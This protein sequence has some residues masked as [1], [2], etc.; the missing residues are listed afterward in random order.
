MTPAE[1]ADA[2]LHGLLSQDEA[3]DF[4]RQ[5]DDD[6]GLREALDQARRRLAVLRESLPPAETPFHLVRATLDRIDEHRTGYQRWRRRGLIAIVAPLATAAVV[7]LAF[8]S[9]YRNLAASPVN[10]ELLGQDQ[11]LAGADAGLRIRLSDRRTQA[12]LAGVPVEITLGQPGTDRFVSLAQFTTD[13][14]GTGR[15]MFRIPDWDDGSYPLRVVAATDR[16]PEEIRQT[17]RLRRSSKLMLTTDKPVYQPGQTIRIRGLILRKPDLKPLAD[18]EAVF[19]VRDPK[20]NTIFRRAGKTSR[21]GITAADCELAD[22]IPDGA[23][24]VRCQVGDTATSATVRVQKYVLA[25]FRVTLNFDRPW[26]TPGEKLSGT[27]RGAYYHGQPVRD[28]EWTL[29]FRNSFDGVMQRLTGKTGP[30]GSASFQFQLPPGL[31][32]IDPD[33]SATVRVAVA[34]RDTAGQEQTVAVTR[35]IVE[36]S[37]LVELIPESG[38]LVQGVANTVYVYAR[39]PD[40]KPS[41]V[42]GTATIDGIGRE[43][44]TDALG[45]GA[46]DVTPSGE[47][48]DVA[49]DAM[50]AGGNRGT[51]RQALTTGR[52]STDFLVRTDKAVYRGGD[53]MTIRVIG[54][55]VEP[56]F[57]DLIKDGQTLRTETVPV[58][59]GA[60]ELI[61]DLPAELAGTIRLCAYRFNSD[62]LPIRKLRL[63]FVRPARQLQLKVATDKPEY[64]PGDP[65]KL[66]FTVT[67]RDG[68]PAPGALSLAAVDEVVFDVLKSRPGMEEAFYLLEQELLKPIYTIYPWTPEEFREGTAERLRFEQAIFSRTAGTI[69]PPSIPGAATKT[70]QGRFVVGAAPHTMSDS[71]FARKSADTARNQQRGLE[72]VRQG[73]WGLSLA[74]VALIY[75]WIWLKVRWIYMLAGHLVFV[76]LSVALMVWTE[77]ATMSFGGMARTAPTMAAKDM[78]RM[79]RPLPGP[80]G[81]SVRVREQFPETLLWRPELITDDAGR[82]DLSLEMA[83][84]ITTWRLTA[85]VIG[86]DGRMGAIQSGIRVFQPFFVDINLPVSLTRGDETDVPVV[87][88]NYVDKP[89]QVQVTLGEGDWFDRM[90]PAERTIELQPNEVKSLSFRVRVKKVGLHTLQIVARTPDLADAV[91]R[92]MEVIP[93]GRRVER[94]INGSLSQPAQ[95]TL[96]LPDNA[97]EGSAKA[98]VKL[99]PSSFSQLIEGLDGIFRLPTG[100]FEQTSSSLYPNVLALRYLRQTGTSQPAIEAKARQYIHVGY[101]RL[102][103]FE[104]AGGGFDWYGRAPGNVG[105][106]AYGLME[107][108]DMAKVHDVDA[109]LINRTRQWLMSKRRA[110]GAWPNDR[111]YHMDP[112]ASIGILRGTA[113]V[114]WA[115][116]ADNPAG[117]MATREFLLTTKPEAITDP[118]VIALVANALLAIDPNDSAVTPYLERLEALKRTSE[119]GRRVWWQLAPNCA[120]SFYGTGESGDVETTAMAVLALQK[121]KMYPVTM[122]GA[123]TWLVEKRGSFGTWGSTQS[124]V[125]ALKALLAGTATA[126]PA[127]RRIEIRLGDDRIDTLVIPADQAEVMK[128]VDLTARLKTGSQI[129]KL[130]EQSDATVGYQIVFRYHEPGNSE[131]QPEPLKIELFYDREN[132]VVGESIVTRATVTN[133]MPAVAPMVMLDLPIPPGFRVDAG[134]WDAMVQSGRI[135]RYQLTP[136]Q[137][138]VYLRRLEPNQR[139]VLSYQLQAVTP[140]AVAVPAARVY[141]YYNPAREGRGRPSRFAVAPRP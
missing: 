109:N 61:C 52:M 114:A 40:G 74:I 37:L 44:A 122:T 13:A 101:Q 27:L 54:G 138:I 86:A 119:D 56:V 140:S 48:V 45:I 127:E 39:T 38:Q 32:P 10:L 11:L 100:C 58:T 124:T 117:A 26:N 118:Y 76:T 57:I 120:T 69:E 89:Q 17:I 72:R 141:E 25:K 21:Y 133:Q 111:T 121:A 23:Y 110:D 98:I 62:G 8:Q 1:R 66:S 139:L 34:L 43:F 28:G 82:A 46:I 36:Q 88:S 103:G 125:L 71:S 7:L 3:A 41:Q 93:D 85:S 130:K 42:R 68:R 16:V 108:I 77:K 2:Y 94:V 35:K 99:Y 64:R 84:S 113:Y 29:E 20:G 105:L 78:E 63:V 90:G 87:I 60:G 97:I 106:T 18:A 126:A 80:G 51:R 79:D 12:P 102:L 4:V 47:S 81:P 24:E 59:N 73:W 65:A 53:T 131:P 49:I 112:D 67:D 129:L 55:G 92:S 33:G 132:V 104:V 134:E 137:V 14:I 107:F 128:Q 135:D 95:H 50:D 115:V 6:A 75:V 5:L 123:L 22:E 19:T 9:Y 91:K 15:V 83:D 31:P 70:L 96:D 136:R 30:D 116:F